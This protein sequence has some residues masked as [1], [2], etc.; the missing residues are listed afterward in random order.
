MTIQEKIWRVEDQI[1][2][3]INNLL[4]GKY[5]ELSS[6][7]GAYSNIIGIFFHQ[8]M[9]YATNYILVRQAKEVYSE[10]INFPYLN[11]EYVKEPFN[12]SFPKP[13]DKKSLRTVTHGIISSLISAKSKIAYSGISDDLAMQ[14]FFKNLGKASIFQDEFSQCYLSNVPYQLSYLSGVLSNIGK[15]VQPKNPPIFID[16][17]LKFANSWI[18]SVKPDGLADYLIVGTNLRLQSRVKSANYLSS[19]RQVIS[20]FH[21]EQCTLTHDDLVMGYGELSY[22]THL[23]SYGSKLLEF[24][25]YNHPLDKSPKIIQRSSKIVENI[26]KSPNILFAPLSMKTRVLYAPTQLSGANRYG[27]FRDIDTVLY[28]KW[29]ETLTRLDLDITYKPHPKSKVSVD[30]SAK[31]IVTDWLQDCIL[32]YDFFFL[33][34]ISTASALAVATDKPIIYF[35][36]GMMN[37]SDEAYDDFRQRVFWVDIDLNGNFE[38]QVNAAIK[39]YNDAK[40]HW[41]NNYTRKYSLN[42]QLDMSTSEMINSIIRS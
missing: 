42:E 40:T 7:F 24:G 27:P 3:E 38:S 29:Q 23:I 39:S 15:I 13:R 37:L 11:T 12:L 4:R 9:I 32:D 35:N 28:K 34:F 2:L 1:A 25:K 36:L 6:E 10:S 20:V 22:C 31:Q 26:Y 30:I 17:F 33:D 16:N 18:S 14:I 5:S 41:V 8:I 19:G 21:G